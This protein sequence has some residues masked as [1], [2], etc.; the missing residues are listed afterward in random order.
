MG[1]FVA[2]A[3]RR[4]AV[5]TRGRPIFPI[6]PGVGIRL[7]LV[8]EASSGRVVYLGFRLTDDL[9]PDCLANLGHVRALVRASADLLDPLGS[10]VAYPNADAGV[11]MRWRLHHRGVGADPVLT[12]PFRELK[13]PPAPWEPL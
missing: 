13:R 10:V 1:Q 5:T 8:H 2:V 11:A 4:C 6:F 12:D 3:G 7:H 9:D